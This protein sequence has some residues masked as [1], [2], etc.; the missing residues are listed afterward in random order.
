[1]GRNIA[2]VVAAL[3]LAGAAALLFRW[4]VVGTPNG[5]YRVDRFT[6]DVRSCRFLGSDGFL[7]CSQ[8]R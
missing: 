3:I 5:L 6:G 7:D 1:V 2:I 4:Q 8:W